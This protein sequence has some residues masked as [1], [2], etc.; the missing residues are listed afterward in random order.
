MRAL[1]KYDRGKGFTEV[2]DVDKPVIKRNSD[3]LIKVKAA[4]IC[5]TDLHIVDDDFI[6]YPPVTLGH[7]F[8]G[9]VEEKGSEVCNVEIGDRVVSEPHAEACMVCDICRR[10]YWQICPEKRS[11]GWGQNGAFTDYLTMP[12]KL[13]H[14]VP[15]KLSD[16]VAAI[17]EPL[18]VA[19][20]YVC[21]RVRVMAQETVVVV[22]SGPIGILCAFAAKENGAG[23]VI[24]LGVDQDE[25]VRF[26]VAL[27]LGADLTINVLKEDAISII[28]EQ[29]EGR[30]ADISIEA[31][32][33]EMGIQTSIDAVRKLG[34][35]CVVGLTGKPDVRVN[36]DTAQK[37][38]LDVFFNFSSS[39][40]S[41]DRAIAI[42][43]NTKMDLTK[44]IT[45]RESI[46]NWKKAFDD[47]RSGRGIK[48]LFIPD[49]ERK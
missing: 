1:R 30:M 27:G 12:A 26:P 35:L 8:V 2:R 34:R 37:K 36:W 42:A 29:T 21:E 3:V 44:L 9:V 16:D 38:I 15:D 32:G 39:Y 46:E 5:G 45:H 6:Y 23:K 18:A 22:G 4:G 25:A 49:S 14:K 40:T 41:W 10:G 24:M 47:L 20:S 28:S 43:S 7:E 31:S 33:S 19:V 48:I 17:I 11:P 13:L